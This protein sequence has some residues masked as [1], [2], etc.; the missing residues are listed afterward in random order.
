M[1][2]RGWQWLRASAVVSP[3]N[4][5]PTTTTALAFDGL[6]IMGDKPGMILEP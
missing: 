5:P 3:A 2:G 1:G 4:P 6:G